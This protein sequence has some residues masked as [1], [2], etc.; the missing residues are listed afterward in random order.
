MPADEDP[1]SI[2]VIPDTTTTDDEDTARTILPT[3]R[4]LTATHLLPPS[5]GPPGRNSRSSRPSTSTPNPDRPVTATSEALNNHPLYYI[6]PDDVKDGFRIISSIRCPSN[7]HSASF[8][9]TLPSTLTGRVASTV[10]S[11]RIQELNKMLGKRTS[12]NDYSQLWYLLVV[13]YF[14]IAMD[15]AVYL[16]TT[17]SVSLPI[18]LSLFLPVIPIGALSYFLAKRRPEYVRKIEREV[19]DWNEKDAPLKIKTKVRVEASGIGIFGITIVIE[20][21]EEVNLD[22]RLSSSDTLGRNS[23]MIR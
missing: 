17:K 11:I 5:Y 12:V 22:Q 18:S 23:M 9:T 7:D 19:Q 4:Y 6:D 2:V 3:N 13:A 14:C 1:P 21:F 20:V 16:S 8:S 10:Y 15:L